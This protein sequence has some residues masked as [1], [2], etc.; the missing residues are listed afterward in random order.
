MDFERL[1]ALAPQLRASFA[2][3]SPF[4]HLVLDDV[5]RPEALEAVIA[6]FPSM[7]EMDIRY[8]ASH[9]HKAARSDL[10]GLDPVVVSTFDELNSD[11]FV[12]W[13][14]SVTGIP[15]LRTDPTN[16]GG[17]V[18][19]SGAGM[20]LD[21]H[22]DFNRHVEFRWFRR[23]NVLLYLNRGW[24]AEHGGVLQLWD[25]E[26]QAAEVSVVPVANR[27]VVFATTSESFHGYDEVRAPE[28]ATRRSF[29]TYYYTE[30]APADWDGSN[31]STLFRLRPGQK[32][33]FGPGGVVRAGAAKVRRGLQIVRAGGR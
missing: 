16:L 10:R 20:Y 26:M 2:S 14:E 23:L 30:E 7:A 15:A 12:R 5:L 27:M 21:V 28:G 1:E 11:R 22:A 17:G 8:K 6:R 13:L 19:Q 24:Q 4:P 9:E 31:H 32:K 18:H 33:R 29:A 25:A 3:A